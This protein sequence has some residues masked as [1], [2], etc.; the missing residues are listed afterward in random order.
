MVKVASFRGA[1]DHAS[2]SSKEKHDSK[3]NV[4]DGHFEPCLVTGK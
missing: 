3:K 1:R 2:A 4:F